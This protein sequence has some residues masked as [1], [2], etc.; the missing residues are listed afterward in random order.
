M[1]YSVPVRLTL[2]DTTKRCEPTRSEIRLSGLRNKLT[3]VTTTRH[4]TTER[5]YL[6]APPQLTSHLVRRRP[7]NAH[8]K[9]HCRP[10]DAST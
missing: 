3:D 7:R 10:Y 1:L 8:P 2:L 6:T 5:T 9:Y 4:L